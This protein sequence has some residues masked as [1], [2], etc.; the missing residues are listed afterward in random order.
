ME[1][2]MRIFMLMTALLLAMG[3]PN[4]VSAQQP[5]GKAP[6]DAPPPSDRPNLDPPRP[7]REARPDDQAPPLP[8]KAGPRAKGEAPYPQPPGAPFQ[9]VPGAPRPGGPMP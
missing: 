1:T 5:K 6:D 4:S 9:T 3:A 8:G 2:I 7:R